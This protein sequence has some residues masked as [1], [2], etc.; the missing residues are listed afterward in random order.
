MKNRIII[1]LITILFSIAGNSR[2]CEAQEEQN[3][4]P[5]STSY[6]KIKTMKIINGDTIVSEKEYSGEGDMQVE[7]EDSILGDN[8]ND[9]DFKMFNNFNDSSFFERFY[10]MPDIFK[11]FNSQPD[12]S[13]FNH[14]NLSQFPNLPIDSI[15]KNFNFY[16]DNFYSPD[17]ETEKEMLKSFLYNDMFN[18][19]DSAEHNIPN[20]D[21]PKLEKNDSDNLNV[22]KNKIIIHDKPIKS[23]KE[24]NNELEITI[25]HNSTDSYF[26]V[27]FEL[28]SKN[29]TIISLTNDNGKQLQK[30][31]I[32]KTEGVYTRQ[33]D[34]KN[35]SKGT[36]YIFIKQ[37]KKE[38]SKEIIIS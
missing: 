37:G 15:F 30:E 3:T 21:N 1:I 19:L 7:M 33:F 25:S 10:K 28:D 34:M 36:Y 35:Y 12:D 29:K 17:L 23:D 11:N 16:N 8:F 6:I 5:Q 2:Y 26:N 24:R 18:S 32:D 31:I 38:V 14:F 27:S 20:V 9:F 22:Q 13:F 4:S